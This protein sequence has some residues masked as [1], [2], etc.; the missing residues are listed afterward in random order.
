MYVEALMIK[1]ANG[2]ARKP[3]LSHSQYC[4]KCRL[5]LLLSYYGFINICTYTTLYSIYLFSKEWQSNVKI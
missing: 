4:M 1:I 2:N 5:T 3:G